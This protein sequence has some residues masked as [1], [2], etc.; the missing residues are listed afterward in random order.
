[1]YIDVQFKNGRP[2]YCRSCIKH[3]RL[4]ED[5]QELLLNNDAEKLTQIPMGEFIEEQARRS[6][7]RVCAL[8]AHTSCAALLHCRFDMTCLWRRLNASPLTFASSLHFF[9]LR[10]LALLLIPWSLLG[11]LAS[12]L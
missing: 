4:S 8:T 10:E 3:E 5:V 2:F 7:E 9:K 6:P 12:L 11:D 1:M